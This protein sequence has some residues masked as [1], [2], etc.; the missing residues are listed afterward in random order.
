M[1][2]YYSLIHILLYSRGPIKVTGDY[3]YHRIWWTFIIGLTHR[4]PHT[5]TFIPAG[6]SESPVSLFCMYVGGN[7]SISK[8][9]DVATTE[10]T[11]DMSYLLFW[12]IGGF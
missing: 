1:D 4:H 10:D 5:L 8:A 12:G 6:N 7:V 11:K 9:R 2:A 3:N